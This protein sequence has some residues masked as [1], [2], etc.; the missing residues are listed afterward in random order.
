MSLE[1]AQAAVQRELALDQ[2]FTIRRL[3]HDPGDNP[4]F[5]ARHE[6]GIEGMRLA[7]GPEE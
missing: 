7:A 4:S 2:R 6:R 1:Q 3:R 5:L